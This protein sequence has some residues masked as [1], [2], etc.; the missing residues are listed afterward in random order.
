MQVLTTNC[1]YCKREVDSTVD[2]IDGPIVCPH[3][4]K[5]FDMEIPKAVVKSVRDVDKKSVDK[6][7]LAAEPAERIL[8]TVHPVV[9]RSRPLVSFVMIVVGLLAITALIMAAAGTT[10]AGFAFDETIMVGP[11]SFLTWMCTFVLL[12]L[13][14]MTGYWLA[15][16]R[17]TTLT[18]TDNRTVYEQGFIS[19]DTSEVQHDDV[20]NLQLDQSF[21]QRLLRVGD[22]GISSS[23]QDDLEV[24]AERVP[25]P[26]RIIDLIRENQK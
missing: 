14:G 25:N 10:V 8:A 12:V 16:S 13:A 22:I 23:G 21:F 4:D 19:R 7:K 15:L 2:N 17:F 18:I 20:R 1:P 26:Q 3:C 9:F 5:P 11:L 6:E 24:V